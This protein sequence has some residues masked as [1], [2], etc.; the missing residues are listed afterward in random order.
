[1]GVLCTA[2]ASLRIRACVRVVKRV[3]D[4]VNCKLFTQFS[5]EEELEFKVFYIIWIRLDQKLSDRIRCTKVAQKPP[6]H[7]GML[8]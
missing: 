4:F 8:S 1:M 3:L 6:I 7:R 2:A 5:R